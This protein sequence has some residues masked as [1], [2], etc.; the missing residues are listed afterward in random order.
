MLQ[1]ARARAV[2]LARRGARL[3][4]RPLVLYWEYLA[5]A[6]GP[7]KGTPEEDWQWERQKESM[8]LRRLPA[9]IRHGVRLY[10]LSWTD[11]AKAAREYNETE[12]H[13]DEALFKWQMEYYEKEGIDEESLKDLADRLRPVSRITNEDVDKGLEVADQGSSIAKSALTVLKDALLALSDGFR[14]GRDAELARIAKGEAV[15]PEL[16]RFAPAELTKRAENSDVRKAVERMLRARAT[17]RREAEPVVQEVLDRAAARKAARETA[18]ADSKATAPK[19]D[20]AGTAPKSDAAGSKNEPNFFESLAAAFRGDKVAASLVLRDETGRRVDRRRD[21]GKSGAR[22]LAKPPLAEA[23]GDGAAAEVAAVPA[24]APAAA[25]AAADAAATDAAPAAGA[26]GKHKEDPGF[27][28]RLRLHMHGTDEQAAAV[29]RHMKKRRRRNAR[30]ALAT[31]P[32]EAER[33]EWAAAHEE[34]A[35]L[36]QLQAPAAEDPHP[37]LSAAALTRKAHDIVRDTVRE[38]QAKRGRPGP[39]LDELERAKLAVVGKPK[40]RIR[41]RNKRE[42]PADASPEQPAA[43]GGSGFTEAGERGSR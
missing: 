41:K 17:G 23:V 22:F 30:R 13:E 26:D 2:D 28:A 6:I 38:M 14:E 37:S 35:A 9:A 29:K 11:P 43:S 7:C 12:D 10:R 40:L 24:D 1:R 42:P 20:A 4:V 19:S 34:A 8:R 16:S 39:L 15:F 5:P 31:A 25:A 18:A 36:A 3:A 21:A 27:L 33:L 32:T